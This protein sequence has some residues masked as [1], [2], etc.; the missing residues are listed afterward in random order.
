MEEGRGV[1]TLRNQKNGILF[2]KHVI[3]LMVHRMHCFLVLDYICD[4]TYYIHAHHAQG[5]CY[6]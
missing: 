6:V 5:A 3:A 4:H 2:T 1:V